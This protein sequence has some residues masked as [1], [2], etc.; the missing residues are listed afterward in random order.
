MPDSEPHASAA[1][2]NLQLITSVERRAVA[3]DTV[4]GPCLN[5]Y[6]LRLTPNGGGEHPLFDLTRHLLA[7]FRQTEASIRRRMEV[8][9]AGSARAAAQVESSVRNSLMRSAGTNY[10]GL[11]S[12]ATARYLLAQESCWFVQHPVPMDF[13]RMLAIRFTPGIVANPAPDEPGI[14]PPPDEETETDLGA[15]GASVDVKPDVDV[16]IRNAAWTPA[17]ASREPILLLSV[18]TSLADR[19]GSAARWKNYFDIVT[20]PCPHQDQRGCAYR[21]LGMSLAHDPQVEITH[22]IVTANIYKVNSDPYYAQYGELRSNQAKSNTFM[23]DLRYAT[24]NGSDD[25]QAPGWEPLSRLPGRLAAMS[26]VF[27]LPE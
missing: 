18:K 8:K 13:G 11:V 10:Q 27:H 1:R 26:A 15:G 6:R 19:A 22:G 9:H 17:R 3:D 12:Y 23:F 7:T 20:S 25:L 16:L 24:R 4:I 21:H 14:P 5:D 2:L